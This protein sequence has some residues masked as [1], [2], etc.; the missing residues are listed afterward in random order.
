MTIDPRRIRILGVLAAAMLVFVAALRVRHYS[1]A[2]SGSK[3][4]S[5]IAPPM[6]SPTADTTPDARPEGAMRW[7]QRGGGINDV[8]CLNPTRIDGVVEVKDA[9]DVS[10]ALSFARANRLNVSIAGARHSQGGQAFA[11]G[12]VVLDMRGFNRISIDPDARTI[13][14]QSGATWHDI[15]NSLHPK[16]AVKAMQSTDVFTVGGSISVNAHGMDHQAGS[17]GGYVQA[18]RVMLA[19]GTIHTVSRTEEPELFRLVIGGYG[20][21]AV[22][23][24]ADIAITENAIYRS[25]REVIDYAGFPS[26][27]RDRIL[28]DER[29]RLLYAHLSTAPQTFHRVEIVY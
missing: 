14:V 17:V 25:E 23:L 4:C 15:Q 20:L 22:I 21:F 10:R 5:P 27:F 8:S 26:F 3:D 29:Y 6:P 13:T 28:A 9:S 7:A 11:R 18:M 12:A 1:A 16:F 24:D 19:D 2:P